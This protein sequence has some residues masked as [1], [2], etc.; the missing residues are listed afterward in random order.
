M[1]QG[2]HK[3]SRFVALFLVVALVA[4]FDEAAAQDGSP[5]AVVQS[6]SGDNRPATLGD[7]HRLDARLTERFNH[8]ENRMDLQILELRREMNQMFYALLAAMVALFGLPHLPA[9]WNRMRGNG[10]GAGKSVAVAGILIAMLAA[11]AAIAA[12]G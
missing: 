12:I 7:I 3:Y 11:S 8:M 5:S 2:I 10:D 1:T 6:Q 9:W 4:P